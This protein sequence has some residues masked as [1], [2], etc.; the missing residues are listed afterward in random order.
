MPSRYQPRGRV[1]QDLNGRRQGDLSPLFGDVHGPE[2][3][4]R[5]RAASVAAGHFTEA[6]VR[7]R[8]AR[9]IADGR[10]DFALVHVRTLELI[11]AGYVGGDAPGPAL[12]AKEVGGAGDE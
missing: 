4:A 11:R 2:L 9:C 3:L 7:E 12:T 8:M 5:S 10:T 1:R 6:A